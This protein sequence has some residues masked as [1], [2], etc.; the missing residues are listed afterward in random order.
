[1]SV[2]F[3]GTQPQ[4]QP[5]YTTIL[6]AIS[7]NFSGDKFS[8]RS[9]PERLNAVQSTPGKML[10]IIFL[11]WPKSLAVSFSIFAICDPSALRCA[12]TGLQFAI[13][14]VPALLFSALPELMCE[15]WRNRLQMK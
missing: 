7:A 2:F 5:H 1:V 6:D 12:E 10:R 3:T 4:S 14:M 13:Q 11:R 15:H 9:V 8:A